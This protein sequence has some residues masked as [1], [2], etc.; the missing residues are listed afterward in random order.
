MPIPESFTD[1]K[2]YELE[3]A[4]DELC[5]LIFLITIALGEPEKGVEYYFKHSKESDKEITL[6]R[7]LRL[8]DW[9]DEEELWL[10]V[11]KYGLAKKIKP[12][13]RLREEYE[14]RLR[15]RGTETGKSI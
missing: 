7:V 12:R 10:E 9:M 4:V 5:G 11:Y 6:Y 2:R 15:E 14:R 8:A 13:D 1:S 3:E